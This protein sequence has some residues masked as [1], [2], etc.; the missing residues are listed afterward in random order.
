MV[1]YKA[2]PVPVGWLFV[3]HRN[4]MEHNLHYGWISDAMKKRL[5]NEGFFQAVERFADRVIRCFL[6]YAVVRYRMK[7]AVRRIR[8]TRVVSQLD[9]RLPEH[10]ARSIIEFIM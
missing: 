10:L 6:Q 1:S 4:V 8:M 9:P 5:Y 2:V 7:K 3:T